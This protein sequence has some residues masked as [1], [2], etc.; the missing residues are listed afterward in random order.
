V[1]FQCVTNSDCGPV[2]DG[3]GGLVDCGGCIGGNTCGGGG[4]ASKC[5]GAIQ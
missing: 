3:C 1:P 4:I 5:G 2:A